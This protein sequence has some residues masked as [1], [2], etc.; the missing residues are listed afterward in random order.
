MA[1]ET[2]GQGAQ[3]AQ[4][5]EAIIAAGGK[6]HIAVGLFQPLGMAFVGAHRADIH[7]GM[8]AQ[9]F[10]AGLDGEIHAMAMGVEHSGVAQVLSI[11]TLAPFA[12]A[13]R[14]MA[15]MSWISKVSEPGLSQNTALVLGLSSGATSAVGA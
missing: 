9:I 12:W 13:A 7:I 15:G 14:E 11:K 3:A 8:A 1:L 6:T 2:D 5:Q 4:R 10:G